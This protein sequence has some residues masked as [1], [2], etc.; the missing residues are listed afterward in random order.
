ML[1]AAVNDCVHTAHTGQGQGAYPSLHFGIRGLGPDLKKAL[2]FYPRGELRPE[3]VLSLSPGTLAMTLAKARTCPFW[4][5]PPV[6]P[7]SGHREGSLTLNY[8]TWRW[9]GSAGTEG[10][11]LRSHRV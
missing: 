2:L 5:A 6:I 8:L 3:V 7:A 4:K 9:P 11:G 10:W 1:T